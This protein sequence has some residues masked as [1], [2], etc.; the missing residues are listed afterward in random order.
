VKEA[1]IEGL[2][3]LQVVDLSKRAEP[4]QFGGTR[5]IDKR[6]SITA[7][8]TPFYFCTAKKHPNAKIAINSMP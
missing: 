6:A 4:Q 2:Q 8:A 3:L 7:S 1:V 5:R